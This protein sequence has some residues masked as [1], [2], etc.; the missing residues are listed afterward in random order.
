MSRV[1]DV[2]PASMTDA[3]RRIAAQIGAARGG[4]VRGPFA[5]WLRLPA[6]AEAANTLGNT[7]RLE[8]KLDKRLF[9]L[10]ILLIA[11]K[12][13][14]QYEWFAHAQAALDAGLPAQTVEAIRV[15]K[16]AVHEREDEQAVADLVGEINANGAVSDAVYAQA[17]QIFGLDLVIELV[18]V[19]GFYTM[20]AVV[21]NAFEAP[22]PG[23]V[24]PLPPT[25][26]AKDR[27]P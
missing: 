2:A 11:K 3:Q 17:L 15:G 8:G 24:L 14:A 6:L 27:Q 21:L 16:G 7:L 26:P 12:W 23:G 5:I 13:N 25:S 22:V 1:E 18:S 9:E 4:V 10:A 19:V 20:V